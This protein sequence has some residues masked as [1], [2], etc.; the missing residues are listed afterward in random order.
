MCFPFKCELFQHSL[1]KL[2]ICL[3]IICHVSLNMF[4]RSLCG[5]ASHISYRPTFNEH[6]TTT[7][8][9]GRHIRQ[10]GWQLQ[11]PYSPNQNHTRVA[12]VGLMADQQYDA[13]TYSA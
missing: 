5:I 2:Q 11:L 1:S 8:T 12:Q 7:R 6:I 13:F 4:T 10:S 3:E 9:W